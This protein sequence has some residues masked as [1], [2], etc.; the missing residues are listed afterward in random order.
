MKQF[1]GYLL[2]VCS[3]PILLLIGSEVWKE[4]TKAKQHG[5]MIEQ[6]IELPEVVSS[7]PVTL[8]DANGQIFS[9][10]YTE[11]SQP[12]SLKDMPELVKQLFI[13]SEDEDFFSH[14]GFDVSAITRAFV[15]NTSDQSIQQGGS[16]ITQQ[17][18]RM[19]YLTEQKTY[20]RKLME[21][22]YAYELEKLYSKEQ[23]L[24]MYLN[25]MY[26]SNQVYG[27][28]AA[29]SYY[30]NKTLAKLSLAEIAFIAAIPNNP[31]LYDPIRNFDKTK[32]RQERLIDKLTEHQIIS[33]AEALT[34]KNE[35]IELA[36]KT[37]IQQYPSYSTYVLQ[38]LK[39]LIAEQTG[40]AQKIAQTEDKM[41]KEYLQL[42]L[43]KVVNDV[44]SNGINIYTALQ[45]EKQA[46]DEAA[47]NAILTVPDLQASA[48]VIDNTTREII[49]IYGGK[50]YKK[51]DLHRAFQSPRQ[52]GS[53]F[54]PLSVYA[55]YFETTNASK[56]ALVSGG[57]YC[58]GNY[59]PENYGRSIYGKVTLTTA[60]KHSI[61]TSALR[62][63]EIIGV[64]TAFQYIDRFQFD[65][66]VKEDRTFAAALGGLNYGVT[67][68]EMA[69]AYSSFVDGYYS[70]AHSI[71]KVTDLDGNL[72]Y[73]WP[74]ERQEIWSAYTVNTMRDILTDVVK[75]GTG[76]GLY[77]SSGY[78]GAKTGTTNQFKDYWV[79]G[80]TNDYTAAVWIGYDTPRS[81]ENI[82]KA[83][84]H[85]S[86][87]NAITN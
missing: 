75:S 58:V 37:K 86:I 36:L 44:L 15:A 73:S 49:S 24:E 61:N 12:M 26:F 87:F 76:K 29:A 69:D 68:L 59:C 48:T 83:K 45:P 2:I 62:L 23:I 66:I 9:E 31:S 77:S 13:L 57:T 39:W 43:K 84:I 20:E 67:T 79:A 1:F 46:Q 41:E 27:I 7:L 50:D 55:P 42:E 65:S 8:Y 21:L 80:L 71:R 30:Y 70:P 72:L 3:I 63:F 10:E 54:K 32:N 81:M 25:E 40:Y 4:I 56:N 34:H 18:V 47:V 5:Q 74:K 64:N 6:S 33:P 11:W 35:T 60:F 52:P 16:T 82:E 28:G 17:L 78:I 53:A 38:E 85:F 51:F 14:I 19:R 22:F